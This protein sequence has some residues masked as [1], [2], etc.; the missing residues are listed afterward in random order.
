MSA[1][2]TSALIKA[3]LAVLA[4]VTTQPFFEAVISKVMVW[5]LEKLAAMTTNTLDDDLVR[6]I[7]NKLYPGDAPLVTDA[8]IQ[9]AMARKDWKEAARLMNLKAGIQP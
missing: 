7:R 6:E 8:D 2:I 1:A 4:S 5:G 9:A 3:F